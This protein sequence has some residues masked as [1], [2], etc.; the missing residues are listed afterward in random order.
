MH[1]LIWFC[2]S[3]FVRQLYIILLVD[4]NDGAD[5]DIDIRTSNSRKRVT[6]GISDGGH[7]LVDICSLVLVTREDP[8]VRNSKPD[9]NTILNKKN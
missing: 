8:L 4:R 9:W 6:N 5:I 2:I 3:Q 7:A 1:T